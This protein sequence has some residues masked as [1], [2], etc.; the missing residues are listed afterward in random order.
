MS[1]CITAAASST[2]RHFYLWPWPKK[3]KSTHRQT[4][5]HSRPGW[6]Y[7]D[8]GDVSLDLILVDTNSISIK[9]GADYACHIVH[10]L[11]SGGLLVARDCPIFCQNYASKYRMITLFN[12]TVQCIKIEFYIYQP[13][14]G[15]ITSSLMF[16]IKDWRL[17]LNLKLLFWNCKKMQTCQNHSFVNRLPLK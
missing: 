13:Y 2:W 10:Q 17:E 8:S 1:V 6:T 12:L 4:Y 3:I 5:T 7:W 9:R 16:Q 11:N 15:W 14:N